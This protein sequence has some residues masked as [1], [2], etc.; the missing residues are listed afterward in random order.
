MAISFQTLAQL[1]ATIPAANVPNEIF[2]TSDYGYVYSNGTSWVTTGTSSTPF[3]A[4]VSATVASSVNNYA[5]AGFSASTTRLILIPASGGSTITGLQAV[6][7]GTSVLIY[8]TS[9]SNN[10]TFVN[11]S[12]SSSAGNL[13]ACAN[14]TNAV[15]QP[16]SATILTYITNQWVFAS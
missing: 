6:S 10:I 8:N 12:G 14:G 5:P 9:S 13:F 7:D 4:S 3:S 2:F 1:T 11:Q 16:T 15:L